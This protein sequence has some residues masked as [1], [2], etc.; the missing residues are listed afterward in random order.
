M[1]T[2]LKGLE[3]NLEA[4]PNL[5]FCLHDDANL[6]PVKNWNKEILRRGEKEGLLLQKKVQNHEYKRGI[7]EPNFMTFSRRGDLEREQGGFSL[8]LAL[9]Y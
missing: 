6:K 4:S 2:G 7:V 8:L 1:P 9:R 5:T 3:K